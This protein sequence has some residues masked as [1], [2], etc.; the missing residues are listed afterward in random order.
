[1]ADGKTN[2]ETL[3]RPRD[4][5]P[6]GTPVPRL[7]AVCKKNV[8]RF[9]RSSVNGKPHFRLS[10][11]LIYSALKKPCRLIS[12]CD[13]KWFLVR[14]FVGNLSIYYGLLFVHFPKTLEAV[15]FLKIIANL[16]L[17]PKTT[18]LSIRKQQA[19]YFS[20]HESSG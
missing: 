8:F 15:T 14:S 17:L 12:R 2:T 9:F 19:L 16:F 5:K 1:M 13:I 20:Y 10:R 18:F 7:P 11:E 6:P 3:H 4:L